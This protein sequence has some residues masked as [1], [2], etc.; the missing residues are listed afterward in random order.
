VFAQQRPEV[1][2]GGGAS[3]DHAQA[4]HLVR[5]HRSLLAFALLRRQSAT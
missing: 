3:A 1:G 5:S 2:R 4:H